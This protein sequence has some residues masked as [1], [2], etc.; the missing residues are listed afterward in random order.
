MTERHKGKFIVVE[1]LDGSGKS[2]QIELLVNFLKSKGKDVILT[3]EPTE[4]SKAGQKIK[5]ILRKEEALEPLEL[6][7]LFVEDRKEHLEK[8]V[9]P[10]LEEG[11]FVVSSRYFFST[12]A[13]GGA[14][15]LDVNML[16]GMNKDFLLPD[17]T[18]IV[19]VLPENCIKRIEDRGE[20]KEFF[21]EIR[22]LEKVSSIYR[23][24]KDMFSN[25]AVVNGEALV[26][27]VFEVIKEA[28]LLQWR[29]KSWK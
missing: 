24:F 28:V 27:D 21:E 9:I 13:Y 20:P 19:E 5:R 29:E 7:K 6:Q 25:I 18:I 12:I 22:K 8:K 2:R 16:C 23:K 11:K 15:G 14:E 4:D 26:E 1:G 17:L 10:A 3:K